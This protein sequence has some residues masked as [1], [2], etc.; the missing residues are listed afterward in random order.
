MRY[1]KL[2]NESNTSND[3]YRKVSS[4]EWAQK[5]DLVTK[6]TFSDKEIDYLKRL[7]PSNCDFKLSNYIPFK[8]DM[9]RNSELSIYYRTYTLDISKAEDEYYY[10]CLFRGGAKFYICDQLD[11][12]KKLLEDEKV[13]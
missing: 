12:L 1:L 7:L 13:I 8:Q 6:L 9:V 11:G 3:Y 10:I 4:V 5:I 2:F